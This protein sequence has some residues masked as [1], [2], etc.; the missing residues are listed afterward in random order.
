[1]Y[2][3]L[4]ICLAFATFF[5]INALA[6]VMAAMLWRVARRPARRWSSAARSNLLFALRT[7]PSMSS[8]VCV[9]ALL[10]PAYI[11]HEPQHSAETVSVKL[12][13]L[14]LL[15]IFGITLALR[16]GLA[17]WRATRRLTA[18]WLRHAEPVHLKDIS[19]PAYRL[20]HSFPVIA[21]VGALRPRLFIAEQLFD[22]LDAEELSAA[23]LHEKAHLVARDNFKRPLVRACSDVLAIVP[24]G[25]TLDR[26]WTEES[27]AAA[28]E[29][30]A[31]TGGATFAL[32]LAAALIKIAR[33]VPESAKPTM[34]AGAFLIGEAG[35][36][37]ASR[38]QH[39]TRLAGKGTQ[40]HPVAP[41]VASLIGYLLSCCFF[42][43]L[44]VL[45]TQTHILMTIHTAIE[46]FV[47]ALQ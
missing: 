31:R 38:V 5:A 30:A 10:L 43:L 32:S 35:A 1:M 7:V 45:V 8:L 6:S 4:G 34:P 36:P 42:A 27:E 21:I 23:V 22:T 24:C 13:L 3:L 33:L 9:V 26:I 16:R 28:D 2:Y 25:R 14:S 17:T 40:Y 41:S 18:D 11:A 12:A 15:S 37:L 46:R 47:A 20:K 44:A 29:Y 39:L 19:I